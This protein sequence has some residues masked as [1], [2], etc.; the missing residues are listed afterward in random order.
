M[1]VPI[2]SDLK[3]AIAKL[4][5]DNDWTYDK[6]GDKVGIASQ[7]VQ[8]WLSGKSKSINGRVYERLEPLILPY[9]PKN[10][11]PPLQEATPLPIS[12]LKKVPIISIASAAGFDPVY[13]PFDDLLT[14]S[15]GDAYFS[16][17]KPGMVAIQVEGDSM[18]P[19]L[20]NGSK[21]L[22]ST[23][24]FPQRG[25]IVVARL[26]DIGIVVKKYHIEATF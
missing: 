24:E 19:L 25:D 14:G 5:S 3:R 21:L 22:V 13:D 8:Q 18:T 10:P 7:S 23:S 20:P 4:L 11:T 2:T 17:V 15:I 6:L 26:K 1:R 16:D 12:A 9:L